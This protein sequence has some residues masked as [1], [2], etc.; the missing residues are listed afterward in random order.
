MMG[1]T[2]T[3]AGI[4]EVVLKHGTVVGVCHLDKL[5]GLLHIAL[6]TEVG[7][8]ILSDDGINEV[9]GVVDMAGEGYD[10]GD[11]AAL[12]SRTAG[13]DREVSRCG[14]VG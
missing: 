5:L 13:E 2:A 6:V 7:N 4:L 8:T 12:G 1:M 11:S 9:V 14:E 10:A 3:L